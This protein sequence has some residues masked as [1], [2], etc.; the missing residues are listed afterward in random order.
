[1]LSVVQFA[2]VPTLP[3][4]LNLA[5]TSLFLR[6]SSLPV[7]CCNTRSSMFGKSKLTSANSLL[8]A[9]LHAYLYGSKVVLVIPG[10]LT[11]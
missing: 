6:T 7:I 10:A 5:A 4:A 3:V 11:S 8:K 9:T 1:M 2:W